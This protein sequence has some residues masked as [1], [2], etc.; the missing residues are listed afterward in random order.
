MRSIKFRQAFAAA[1]LGL[2]AGSLRADEDRGYLG[3]GLDDVPEVVA[4]HIRLKGGALVAEVV[5]GGP[6][7]KAGIQRLDVIATVAGEAVKD[8]ESLREKVRSLK[9]GD[10][11]RLGL[12]RGSESLDVEVTL[13]SLAEAAGAAKAGEA[14]E[15][16]QHEPAAEAPAPEEPRAGFLGVGFGDVP[17]VLAEHLGLGEG[18]GILVNDLWADSP[19]QKAGIVKNDVVL[20]IDGKELKGPEDFARTIRGKKIGE[21]VTLEWVHKGKRSSASVELAERP[22]NLPGQGADVLWGPGGSQP[23]QRSG[24]GAGP[25]LQ[26]RGRVIIEGP[27]GKSWRLEVPDNFWN[28]EE[29]SKDF[30]ARLHALEQELEKEIGKLHQRIQPDA[31]SRRVRSL[32]EHLKLEDEAGGVELTPDG[33]QQQ[34]SSHH[35]VL[36]TV[37]GGL[38][39]TVEDLNG[40]RT[41]TVK[42][43]DKTLANKLPWGQL[44]TLPQDIRGRV[45][46]LAEG[47]KVAP[48]PGQVPGEQPRSKIK[49]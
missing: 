45:E 29:L 13:G 40:N 43:G 39:I 36:R 10:T 38:D 33:S 7:E 20:S 8:R 31:L 28:A 34:S 35:A 27:N 9:P 21:K 49:A 5:A 46:K 3:I 11:L 19:A 14:G 30:E 1:L 32:M 37:E 12:K 24:P 16:E 22:A 15:A 26:R 18:V 42:Q 17:S 2:C 6:A 44:E 4:H 48:A 25:W 41:V 23:W 47:L